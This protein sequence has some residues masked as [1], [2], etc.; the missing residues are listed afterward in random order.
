MPTHAS[1]NDSDGSAFGESVEVTVSVPLLPDVVVT[2]GPIPSVTGQAAPAFDESDSLASVSVGASIASILGTDLLTIL[3]TGLLEVTTEGDVS[4]YVDSSSTVNGVDLNLGS[5]ILLGLTLLLGLD[6]DTI[7]STASIGGSCGALAPSGA[8]LLENAVLSGTVASA[9]GI[10]GLVQAT[11]APNTILLA[12]DV[13]IGGGDIVDIMVILNE[14]VVGGDGVTSSSITVNAI[15]VVASGLDIGLGLGLD[16]EIIIGQSTAS[17]DC[18]LADLAITMTDMPDPV[19]EGE[20]LTYTLTVSNN[21]PDE[22]G[23]VLVS[24]LLPAGVDFVSATPDQGSCQHNAGVVDC[25]LGSLAGA[26]STGITIVVTPQSAGMI[27]N[28]ATVTTSAADPDTSN[29]SASETTTVNAAIPNSDLSIS[30]SANPDPVT[31]GEVLTY[32][33]TVSNGGPDD[34]PDVSMTDMLSGDVTFQSASASQ[35]S[36]QHNAGTVSCDFGTIANGASATATIMVVPQVAGQLSNTASVDSGADDPNPDDNSV[37]I[38]TTVEAATPNSDLS[39]S[40]SANPDPVTVGATLTYTVTVSNGGPDDAPDVNMTDML[41]GDVTFQSAA[42]S[43]GSCQHNAGTVSCAFGMITNG[44]SATAT[45]MVVPQVAGQ[46]SNTASVDSGADDPNPGDNSV[47]IMTTVEEATAT[48]DLAISKS[49]N[50]DPVTVGEML[51][52]T[53]MVSNGGP[54]DAPDVNVSDMLSA[55]V[56][57]QSV[58]ASQGSCQHNA[59]TVSCALGTVANSASATV[60]IVVIPQVAGELS[61]TAA[62]NSGADDPNPDDNSVTITTTVDAASSSSDLAVSTVASPDPV[63][64]GEVLTYTITVTNGGPDEAPDVNLSDLLADDVTFQSVSPSQGSCQHSNGTVSCT[65]GALASG[66]SAT[67]TVTVVPQAAGQVANTASVTGGNED[68]N[69]DDN[70]ATVMTTVEAADSTSDLSVSKSASPDPVT[71]GDTLTY[72]LTVSN[73]GPDDAPDVSVTDMLSGDVTF[74][75]A[76]ASQGSCQHSAGTV[77]C[78]LGTIANGASATATIMV[79]PQVAGELSN[80]ASVNAASNDPNPDDNSDTVTTTV[81]PAETTSDL[82]IEKTADRPQVDVGEN[83]TYSI[84]VANTGPED[85]PNVMVTDTLSA[86]ASFVSMSTTS[87]SCQ[88]VAP[89][90]TCDLGTLPAG[91]GAIITLVVTA[92]EAGQLDNTAAVSSGSNDP[93]EDDNDST[94]TVVV[95]PPPAG[96]PTGADLRMAKLSRP[97]AVVVGDALTYFLVVTNRGPEAATDVTV[98]DDLP[99]SFMIT[100]VSTNR[101]SCSVAGQRVTCELGTIE[102]RSSAIVEIE[103]VTTVTGVL[104][105]TAVV[106]SPDEDPDESDNSSTSSTQVVASADELPQLENIPV[107]TPVAMCLLVINLLILGGWAI[108]RD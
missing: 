102:F 3:E 89:V 45:I 87:G 97:S 48:S 8:T 18:D 44:A 38:M 81:E 12:G 10:D 50:P 72:T 22:A 2:S 71:V 104:R 42:A 33:V 78:A 80:T 11:P 55:N 75:S 4:P 60:T 43:Q 61:N 27:T 14:Q 64:V 15:R 9:V 90:V 77:S 23:A 59:G 96:P 76:S 6:A 29:N 25:D 1:A 92:E 88:H 39:I 30:K 31:V 53:I 107:M 16:A 46:L 52:Y 95:G 94:T 67:I 21:G 7:G 47:T 24:D 56:T 83:V 51:T 40:K 34:A 20:S 65:L 69:L 58:A 32:T 84:Q 49:A 5:D 85:A 100:T 82:S 101:G 62:V 98:T 36:C 17:A 73:A 106:S 93:D 28:G 13:D 103:G 37:T 41:S 63:T 54:D 66:G 70:S 35:G 86:S 26:A 74:Q 68:P 108:R 19:T 105:N 99:D 79:V 57:F 91:M